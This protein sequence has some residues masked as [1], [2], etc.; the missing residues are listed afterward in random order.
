MTED[1]IEKLSVKVCGGAFLASMLF[2]AFANPL[3]TFMGFLPSITV[4]SVFPICL[5]LT[6]I[7]PR[8]T[9]RKV[10]LGANI[11]SALAVLCFILNYYA[12]FSEPTFY[13][14]K[15]VKYI[16]PTRGSGA[17]LGELYLPNGRVETL[18][19]TGS[20][21]DEPVQVGDWGQVAVHPGLFGIPHR[22]GFRLGPGP[23]DHLR[24][25]ETL[26]QTKP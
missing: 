15:I 7:F 23:N 21:V 14:A 5:P 11:L 18:S 9:M 16:R 2:M 22:K 4:L 6:W 20:D 26:E 24:P 19:L 1:E 25:K 3:S 8:D 13:P 10:F 17:L 12:D